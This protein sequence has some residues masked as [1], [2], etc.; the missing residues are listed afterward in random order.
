MSQ[1]RKRG[2]GFR[3]CGGLY[4]VGG[5][6]SVPC[7]RLPFEL[8]VCPTCSQG[9]KQ[10]MGFTWC[11]VPHLFQGPHVSKSEH[12]FNETSTGPADVLCNCATAGCPLCLKPEVL[13]KAGL[14]WIGE[15]FYKTPAAFLAEGVKL[16]FSRR[17]K[18]IP[19][20]FKIGETWVLLAHKNAIVT[21]VEKFLVNKPNLQGIT[22]VDDFKPGIF[23]VWRPDRVELI[24]K[25]SERWSE[26]VAAA[27]KRGIVPVFFPDSDTDHQGNVHDD[28]KREQKEKAEAEEE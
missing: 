18:T 5:S 16:G 11:D 23:Y 14:L 8:S 24:F 10:A 6:I 15:K 2:C 22:W 27:E 20:G 25:E 13:G 19:H 7:D 1:E 28:F 21:S 26:K 9:I 17:I 12:V 4:L 3:K